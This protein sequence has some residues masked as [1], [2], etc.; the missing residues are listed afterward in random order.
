MVTTLVERLDREVVDCDVVTLDRPGPMAQRLSEAGIRVRPLG[1]SGLMMGLARLARILRSERYDVVNAYGFKSTAVVRVLVR[2]LATNTSFI[3]GVRGL[4][5]TE[6]ERVDSPKGRLVLALERL[7]SRLVDMYDANSLGA[8]ELLARNGV[9]RRHLRYIPNGIDVA[10]WPPSWGAR[11]A[12][13]LPTVLCVA[14]FTPIKRH[15]D[16]VRAAA[17]LA[18]EGQEFR[19]IMAGDGPTRRQVRQLTR[20]LGI[21]DVV[22]F[23]GGVERAEVRRLLSTADVFCLVSLWE[24]MP[25]A[26]M[27]AMASGLPVVGTRVNG[28]A[29]L[30]EEGR[31]GLLVPPDDPQRL[32]DALGKLL[33]DR[34]WRLRLGQAGRA[35]IEREFGLD[36]MVA[37]KQRLYQEVAEVR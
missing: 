21:E 36:R 28:I 37:A 20:Q 7:G 23:P 14:R 22:A 30:V 4:N 17:R 12:G 8:I 18:A 2:A 29:E 15:E 24:G 19:L 6:S 11:S 34:A 16:L 1:G 35:R 13:A 32:A 33:G 27:E 31:T 3:S 9:D 25:S 26:V 5:I 10:E